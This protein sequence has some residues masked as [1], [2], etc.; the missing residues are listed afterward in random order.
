M[1]APSIPQYFRDFRYE[2]YTNALSFVPHSCSRFYPTET[3][4]GNWLSPVLLLAKDAA[5]TG[6]M[7]ALVES[8]GCHGWRH[9]ERE[10]GDRGGW[11]T[12]ER[13]VELVR[14]HL[15]PEPL[16]G[17]ATANML[18]DDPQ[19]SRSLPGFYSGHLHSYLAGVL[20]WVIGGMPNLRVIACVGKEAWYL[21][22]VVL[23]DP[24]AARQSREFRDEQRMLMSRLGNREIAASSHFHPARGS[25]EQWAL[26][27]SGV[28]KFV[29]SGRG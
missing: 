11:R 27:W 12:N 3:L 14:R 22:S 24:A 17:S 23:G 20:R 13:L 8:G 5:P 21:T 19:W 1:P 18:Y 16:Y 26:G 25:R 4:F 2:G 28:A 7:R 15:L 29:A 6:V 10:K 9:A